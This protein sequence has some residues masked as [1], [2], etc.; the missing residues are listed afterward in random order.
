MLNL[1]PT[2]FIKAVGRMQWR[3]PALQSTVHWCADFFRNRDG[4][5]SHGVGKGLRFNVGNANAGFFLGTSEP[6]V[7]YV[8]SLLTCPGMV[9]YD[10]GANV[11]FLT[12]IAARLVAPRGRVIA[13]EPLPTNIAALHHNIA[14]NA[15]THV[16]V[17][18]EALG[19]VDAA[20]VFHVSTNPT[21]GKLASFGKEP[22]GKID[23]I[24]VAIRRLDSVREEADLPLPSLMKIDV[25][26]AEADV[27]D[28]AAETLRHSRPLL[29]IELHGTNRAV[30]E[31]LT[32]SRYEAIV[33]GSN[34]TITEA[35]WY[36]YIIAA[37]RE[38]TEQVE[39]IQQFKNPSL[40]NR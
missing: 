1:L 36:A 24:D 22:G 12:V 29:L 9:V 25:E 6:A 2:K 8:L 14:L 30:A 27:L 10:A 4:V 17:R 7:Q 18:P 37:P 13:F 31:R 11:G 40:G 32:R 15:F 35:P 16:T 21:W 34:A 38:N 26:G 28:G 20:A 5:I 23:E 39:T 33:L 19:A 3:S